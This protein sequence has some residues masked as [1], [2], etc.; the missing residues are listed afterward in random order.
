MCAERCTRL[1]PGGW[2]G[3]KPGLPGQ[4]KQQQLAEEAKAVEGGSPSPSVT[5]GP[6]VDIPKASPEARPQVPTK[7]QVP[8]K[9]QE[10]GSSPAGRPTPAPRKASEN[11]ALTPPTPRPRSSLQHENSGEHGGS[12]S[13]VNGEQ[14]SH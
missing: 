8:G 14:A 6:E 4:P 13:L 3:A 10:L 5:T 11:T 2:S 1:G 9:L 7:P 12:S